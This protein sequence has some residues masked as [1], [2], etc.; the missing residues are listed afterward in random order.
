M[1]ILMETVNR[2]GGVLCIVLLERSEGVDDG[3]D[4]MLK[5]TLDVVR[6]RFRW[7]WIICLSVVVDKF[8]F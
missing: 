1:K 3:D 4:G 6:F 7:G 8:G 2:D 5:W